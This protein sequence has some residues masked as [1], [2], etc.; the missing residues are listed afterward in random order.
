MRSSEIESPAAGSIA[1]L[2]SMNL[3]LEQ[4]SAHEFTQ[5]WA[6][7]NQEPGKAHYTILLALYISAVHQSS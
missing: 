4:Y 1:L 6:A 7:A 2:E 5:F 3:V